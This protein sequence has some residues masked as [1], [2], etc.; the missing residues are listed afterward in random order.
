MEPENPEVKAANSL[1]K[2]KK[3]ADMTK[4]PTAGDEVFKGKATGARSSVHAEETELG[5]AKKYEF[6]ADQENFDF[7]PEEMLKAA[8]AKGLNAKFTYRMGRSK[9][10]DGVTIKD[11]PAKVKKF[12]SGY[13]AKAA[14]G[15][16]YYNLIENEETELAEGALQLKAIPYFAAAQ[17]KMLNKSD[18]AKAYMEIGKQM[19]AF[20]KKHIKDKEETN[21][22]NSIIHIFSRGSRPFEDDFMFGSFAPDNADQ[23]KKR[24][25]QVISKL[26]GNPKFWKAV[27]SIKEEVELDEIKANRPRAG[28]SKAIENSIKRHIEMTKEFVKKGMS[29]EAASKKAFDIITS[30]VKEEV[31]LDEVSDAGKAVLAAKGAK[32]GIRDVHKA[33]DGVEKSVDDAEDAAKKALKAKNKETRKE[34]LESFGSF[35]DEALSKKNADKQ[36]AGMMKVLK[37]SSLEFAQREVKRLRGK[38]KSDEAIMKTLQKDGHNEDAILKAV[39]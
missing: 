26:T 30:G 1:K 23:I 4:H 22:W 33:A 29:Q 19:K 34:G 36:S 35:I 18:Q 31:E 32:R 14:K 5:E 10:P 11:D 28:G 25:V 24:V 20:A 12:I 8:K 9:G 16:D 3:L 21:Y 39:G 15:I 13:D 2:G 7:D 17:G 27:A 6:N 37:K 38:G